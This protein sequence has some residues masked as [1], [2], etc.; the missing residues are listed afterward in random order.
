MR[1]EACFIHNGEIYYRLDATDEEID[2]DLQ[3][4]VDDS[5]Y[6][7]SELNNKIIIQAQHCLILRQS[8]L[9]LKNHCE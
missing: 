4:L 3:S 1:E 9:I 8:E 6:D 2:H 7:D 5:L